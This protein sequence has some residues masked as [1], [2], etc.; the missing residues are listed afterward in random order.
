MI[1]TMLLVG[2]PR[3]YSMSL[4]Y[5]GLPRAWG[6]P[7]KGTWGVMTAA[8]QSVSKFPALC[9][10]VA[11]MKRSFESPTTGKISS[12]DG[13]HGLNLLLGS[14]LHEGPAVVEAT[15]FKLISWRSLLATS[16]V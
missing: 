7:L 9:W 11:A 4:M 8:D 5:D 12:L 16:S 6:L 15:Y 2:Y 10:L 14:V 3:Q 13:S 1:L